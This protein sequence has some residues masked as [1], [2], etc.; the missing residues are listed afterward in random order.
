[1]DEAEERNALE[2]TSFR[3]FLEINGIFFVCIDKLC[4]KNNATCDIVS[5]FL[6]PSNINPKVFMIYI[7][8][9]YVLGHVI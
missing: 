6:R 5:I 4:W 2:F 8:K 3:I 9:H 7:I 1:M